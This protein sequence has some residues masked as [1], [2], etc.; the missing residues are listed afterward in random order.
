VNGERGMYYV[1]IDASPYQDYIEYMCENIEFVKHED[2]LTVRLINIINTTPIARDLIITMLTDNVNIQKRISPAFN[3]M[4]AGRVPTL[5]VELDYPYL[6]IQAV[7]VPYEKIIVM[8]QI[9]GGIAVSTPEEPS[10]PAVKSLMPKDLLIGSEQTVNM[11]QETFSASVQRPRS[12]EER[13]PRRRS[14]R[15]QQQRK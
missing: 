12:E 10:P 8:M 4:V 1:V 11:L 14:P 3:E 5:A 2:K 13:R 7:E 9:R 15:Q 6:D